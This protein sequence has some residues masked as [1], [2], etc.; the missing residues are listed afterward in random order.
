M[1]LLKK[2]CSCGRFQLIDISYMHA[3]AT[4]LKHCIGLCRLCSPCYM[5]ESWRETFIDIKYPCGHEDDWIVAEDAR[6]LH[7]GNPM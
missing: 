6:N 2:E 3:I 1:N 7:V 4:I 5:I